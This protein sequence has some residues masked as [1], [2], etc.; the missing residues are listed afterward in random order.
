MYGKGKRVT[1]QHRKLAGIT[2]IKINNTMVNHGNI[3]F[4]TTCDEKDFISDGFFLQTHN[5]GPEKTSDKPKLRDALQIS[6]Q[7][8]S[9]GSKP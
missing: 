2:F 5:P 1:L 9:K 4:L 8:S 6:D 7:Y 3:M